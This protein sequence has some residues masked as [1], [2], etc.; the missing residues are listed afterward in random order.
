MRLTNNEADGLELDGEDIEL[1]FD[2]DGTYFGRCFCRFDISKTEGR[3]T[4]DQWRI[5]RDWINAHILKEDMQG[6]QV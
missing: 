6:G 3:M 4:T 1:A 2:S 5:I